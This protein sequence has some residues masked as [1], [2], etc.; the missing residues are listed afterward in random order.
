M[1]TKTEEI[2][3]QSKMYRK[4]QN[5]MRNVSEETLMEAHRKQSG[6]KAAGADGVT[7]DGYGENAEQNI[8]EL[9]TRMKTFSYRPQPVRRTYIPKA[10][11]KMRPL[12]IPA[13][14]DKLVQSVMADIL[15]AVYEPRFLDCSYGFREK[16][17]AH[18]V[19]R[20]I[21]QTVMTK[22]VNYVLEA[23]IKG[24]FDNVDHEWMMKFLENDIADKNFLRYITRF[25][26]AGVME[27]TEIL[28]ADKGT[29][30]GGL[31][32]PVL[33]NVYLHYVLDLWFEKYVKGNLTGDA[34]Y[35]RYAD[36]FLILFEKDT[37]ARAVMDVL[38]G[39]L[40][41]FGLELAEDKT[42]VL[43]FG[44]YKGTKE[45]FDFLG[46]TFF[47][48]TTR[49]GKYRVGVKSSA[50]KMKAKRQAVK[51]W[52]KDRL[53]KP[54]AETM[55][56]LH[57]KVEGHYNYYGISGNFE[58]IRKF[59]WYVKYTTFRMFNRRD[60]KGKMKPKSFDRIW[61]YYMKPPRLK[62]DIWGWNQ[63]VV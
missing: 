16:R 3:N 36:D 40:A 30:Q 61:N 31:I 15:N 46:F 11:G 56:T 52:L 27:G 12:G 29:P 58:A 17:S 7:K 4:V 60:Q 33:A 48:T 41:K 1:A 21:N 62:V 54:I 37:D 49:T 24:F 14:E 42:R 6:K 34:Y 47:N 50:K 53:T 57:R 59:T 18:D 2:R 43:P 63:M 39:R 9:I 38:P 51:A 13:Y 22:R 35:V 32:S 5:L 28:E 23:D 25:L 26:K 45:T 19:V 55:M 44:R 8:Q 10:N 20:F